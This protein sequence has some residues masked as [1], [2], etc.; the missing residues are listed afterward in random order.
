MNSKSKSYIVVDNFLQDPDYVLDM[1]ET[2]K[3]YSKEKN[4]I[5]GLLLTDNNNEVPRGNWR[6]Y[7]SEDLSQK[8]Y[9]KT[10]QD[11]V[12]KILIENFDSNFK[13]TTSLFYLHVS[14][15]SITINNRTWHVDAGMTYAGVIYMNPVAPSNSGT[16]LYVD[17]FSTGIRTNGLQVGIQKPGINVEIENIYNR[18]LVYRA[19]TPHCPAKCFG[20]NLDSSRKT[21]TMFIT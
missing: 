21:I 11:N 15:E 13:I 5:P 7:R 3:F 1:F 12:E 9:F 16:L 2:T 10:L 19:N 8:E 4:T 17:E 6:G 20:N 14:C 18:L